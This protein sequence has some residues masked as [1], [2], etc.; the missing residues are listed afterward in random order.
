MKFTHNPLKVQLNHDQ[1]NPRC[2]WHKAS[3]DNYQAYKV[4]LDT[5]LIAIEQDLNLLYCHDNS[6][7]CVDHRNSIDV[8][9][10]SI[11]ECCLCA[12]ASTIPQ[13]KPGVS[14]MT[15]TMT[16]TMK[17]IYLNPTLYIQ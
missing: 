15:M 8:L 7:K 14:K 10:N 12:S 11:I 17:Y 3:D 4:L 2:A 1:I 9:C 16:M 13:T 5:K 6:C